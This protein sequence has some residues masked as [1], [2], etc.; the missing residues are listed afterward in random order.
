[1]LCFICPHAMPLPVISRSEMTSSS[2]LWLHLSS[3]SPPHSEITQFGHGHFP[4]CR[5][6]PSG[7]SI[8]SVFHQRDAP[9]DVQSWIPYQHRRPLKSMSS[10]K[11]IYHIAVDNFLL[12]LQNP[13]STPRPTDQN[14]QDHLTSTHFTLKLKKLLLKNQYYSVLLL[15]SY[16]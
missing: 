10:A 7:W 9:Q 15:L 5:S 11:S 1:M 14:L 8:L 12:G 2:L 16:Q 6:S 4:S 13:V 3:R